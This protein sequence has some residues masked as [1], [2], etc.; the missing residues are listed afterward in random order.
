MIAEGLSYDKAMELIQTLKDAGI[1]SNITVGGVR[2]DPKESQR[3]TAIKIAEAAGAAVVE[4]S[5]STFAGYILL[6]H[7]LK[8][9]KKLSGDE[10]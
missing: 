3:S 5:A 2:I 1:E 9:G 7:A 8:S 6:G 4:G 10:L